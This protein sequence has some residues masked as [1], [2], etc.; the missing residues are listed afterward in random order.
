MCTV[1]YLPAEK[2]SY[3]LT[4][5]RDEKIIRPSAFFP[6]LYFHEQEK[7]LYPKDPQAGGTWIATNKKGRTVC[8][9]NGAFQKHAAA[10]SYRKSRGLV[11][12]DSFLANDLDT[13]C[14]YYDFSNIEPFT[15][16]NATGEKLEEIR[17]DGQE[18]HYKNLDHQSA[19]IW[20]SVTL[21]NEE[22]VMKRQRWF[23]TWLQTK[24]ETSV[25]EI[26]HFHRFAGEGSPDNDVVINR[27]NFMITQSITS[28]EKNQEG[29]KMIYEDLFQG[30]IVSK[31]LKR[32]LEIKN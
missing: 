26:R 31:D 3:F 20:S 29:I 6:D 27:D 1:T 14:R 16:L 23:E 22:T 24:A 18:M 7:L 5:N 19:F 21:Y 8:L 13:F 10:S 28:V 9:L 17:W 15:L 2:G 32:K 12:L 4:S 30:T 11:L 25:E